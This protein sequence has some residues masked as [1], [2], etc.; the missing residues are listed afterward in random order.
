MTPPNGSKS[1]SSSDS[2]PQ[3]PYSPTITTPTVNAP[4]TVKFT[5][6]KTSPLLMSNSSRSRN[7]TEPNRARMSTSSASI[8]TVHTGSTDNPVT[9]NGHIRS[10][11]Y[12]SQFTSSTAQTQSIGGTSTTRQEP[13]HPPVSS[14]PNR[15]I[16]KPPSSSSSNPQHV[17]SS[18]QSQVQPNHRLFQPGTRSTTSY[19]HSIPTSTPQYTSSIPSQYPFS[20]PQY[21]PMNPMGYPP[22]PPGVLP[23]AGLPPPQLVQPM[24]MQQQQMEY[25]TAM[26]LEMWKMAQEQAYKKEMGYVYMYI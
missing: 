14:A 24:I 11:N 17:P 9:Q 21:I 25:Q 2:T 1:S 3:R 18:I 15:S 20:I 7:K 8:Q 23:P 26:E 6:P 10:T 19:T 4:S 12:T 13:P 5:S 16:L 22:P